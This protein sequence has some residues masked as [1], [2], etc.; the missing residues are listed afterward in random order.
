[1]GRGVVGGGGGGLQL[2]HGRPLAQTGAL[3]VVG[4]GGGGLQL[5]H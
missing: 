2:G 3:V 1:M 5:G 4:G